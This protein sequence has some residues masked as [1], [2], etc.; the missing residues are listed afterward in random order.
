MRWI[1]APPYLEKFYLLSTTICSVESSR[2]L[3]KQRN[4]FSLLFVNFVHIVLCVCMYIY[5]CMCV[6]VYI[7]MYVCVYIYI[8]MNKIISYYL[9]ILSVHLTATP[10]FFVFFCSK[11]HILIRICIFNIYC[12]LAHSKYPVNFYQGKL[13][14]DF[15]PL[16]PSASTS[17][18][19]T[20]LYNV[21]SS[22]YC[23]SVI[24]HSHGC[25]HNTRTH[26]LSSM[27]SAALVK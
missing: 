18:P 13:S 1:S 14:N 15:I 17:N 3:P 23:L 16:S 22:V 8:Y 26:S 11:N 6:Y 25:L 7:R 19:L 27:Y 2:T 10:R 21:T 12:I 4:L 5:V 20:T 9:S 24:F